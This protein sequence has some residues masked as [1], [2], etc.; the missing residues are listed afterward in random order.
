[1]YPTVLA[2]THEPYTLARLWDAVVNGVDDLPFPRVALYTIKLILH[3]GERLSLGFGLVCEA[4]H[5]LEDKNF[6]PLTL[7]VIHAPIED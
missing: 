7:D 2:D 1:M 4:L 6:G 5:I 3:V